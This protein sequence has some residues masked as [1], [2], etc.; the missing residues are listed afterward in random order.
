[1]EK[2]WSPLAEVEKTS[3]NNSDE[4][5]DP[6]KEVL[7]ELQW[8]CISWLLGLYLCLSAE[9]PNAILKVISASPVASEPSCLSALQTLWPGFCSQDFWVAEVQEGSAWVQPRPCPAQHKSRLVRAACGMSER[10]VS[11]QGQQEPDITR[12]LPS[13]GLISI[14]VSPCSENAAPVGKGWKRLAARCMF[15]CLCCTNLCTESS[16]RVHACFIWLNSSF[17]LPQ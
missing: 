9:W 4:G 13:D 5:S 11:A 12:P 8:E 16:W 1:M 14:P 10:G 6:C 15:G 7:L 2:K 17:P 3:K